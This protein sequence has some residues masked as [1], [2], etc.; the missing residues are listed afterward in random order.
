MVVKGIFV[1][2][3]FPKTILRNDRFSGPSQ[4]PPP[5]WT[6]SVKFDPLEKKIK[7]PAHTHPQKLAIFSL[8]L[9]KMLKSKPI[10]E[11]H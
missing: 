10:V 2:C 6:S 4:N 11:G 7:V 3:E 8:P 5:L 9:R 1:G